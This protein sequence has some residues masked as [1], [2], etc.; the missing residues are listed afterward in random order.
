M[1]RITLLKDDPYG[2]TL[3]RGRVIE[4]DDDIADEMVRR[5]FARHSTVNDHAQFYAKRNVVDLAVTRH[6][7]RL[8]RAVK[9][10]KLG[11]LEAETRL[12]N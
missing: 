5:G 3:V 7:K 6:G 12:A 8:D 1:K 9:F 2:S 10:G 11:M 4:F